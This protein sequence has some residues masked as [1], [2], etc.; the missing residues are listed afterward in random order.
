MTTIQDC[1]YYIG[2][3]CY[4][5]GR[6]QKYKC[7][8]LKVLTQHCKYSRDKKYSYQTIRAEGTAKQRNSL[9]LKKASVENATRVFSQYEEYFMYKA[10]NVTLNQYAIQ[11]EIAAPVLP[12]SNL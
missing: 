9:I 12:S 10:R 8:Y 7:Y 11:M 5:Y 1:K 4:N 2:T 3:K 6:D